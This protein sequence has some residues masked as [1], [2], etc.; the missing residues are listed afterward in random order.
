MKLISKGAEANI[1]LTQE[2]LILKE[3]I[4]KKYRVKDLD[5]YLRTTRTRKEAKLLN[6]SKK[7]GVPTPFVFDVD[8]EKKSILMSF[9]EGEKIRDYIENVDFEEKIKI[10]RKIGELVAKLHR[11]DII[12]GD[13]T[14]SNM[15]INK[16]KIY[17]IDF[18]LGEISM[19]IE[20]KA[21]DVLLFKKCLHSS[22][23]KNERECY[24]AF[25]EGYKR[26]KKSDDVLK[27][28][29]VIER[30]GR[31]FAERF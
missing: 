7:A 3:R 10:C 21:V 19:D 2:G 11:N 8:L 15:I 1:Y 14:T 24:E 30:R 29:G 26:Y 9:V 13:L 20:D 23:Y 31:Y 18:G 4:R 12:H 5:E 17:F 28:V 6:L 25:I 22:H 27:R 16:D